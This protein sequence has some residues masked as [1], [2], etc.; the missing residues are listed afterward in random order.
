MKLKYQASMRSVRG[1]EIH[2]NSS[3]PGQNGCHFS[4][5]IFKRIMTDRSH[6]IFPN[7]LRCRTDSRL[8]F[9]E[10]ETSSQSNAI[11]HWLGANLESAPYVSLDW[12]FDCINMYGYDGSDWSSMSTVLPLYKES[13]LFCDFYMNHHRGSI[14]FHYIYIYTYMQQTFCST[15]IYPMPPNME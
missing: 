5:D 3:P 2:L 1:N 15:T 14:C 10:W 4:D 6:L 7:H 13:T 12:L 8:V 11:S 9:N